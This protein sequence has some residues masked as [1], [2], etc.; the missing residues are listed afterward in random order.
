MSDEQV[1]KIAQMENE[2]K[3]LKSSF[4]SMRSEQLKFQETMLKHMELVNSTINKGRGAFGVSMVFAGVFGAFSQ[5][6]LAALFNT[7]VH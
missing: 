1:V 2:L 4:D 5:K 3:W 7:G 6:I